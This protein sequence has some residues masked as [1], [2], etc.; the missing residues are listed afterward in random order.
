MSLQSSM[1]LRENPHS[2]PAFDVRH[3]HRCLA[4]LNE[5]RHDMVSQSENLMQ[6]QQ[7]SVQ[8]HEVLEH[9]LNRMNQ[10]MSQSALEQSTLMELQEL[11]GALV[12]QSQTAAA[13]SVPTKQL[14]MSA[15]LASASPHSAHNNTKLAIVSEPS[16]ASNL[17]PTQPPRPAFLGAAIAGPFDSKSS[18][19]HAKS[20]EAIPPS[21]AVLPQPSGLMAAAG[22]AAPSATALLKGNVEL[23]FTQGIITLGRVCD[24]SAYLATGHLH[25]ASP[26]GHLTESAPRCV[27]CAQATVHPP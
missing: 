4:V 25:C 13:G 26:T 12:I 14:G 1:L 24:P 10:R 7:K 6:C 20:S 19:D 16:P 2:A 5:M 23:P 8:L 22:S 9:T 27:S 21:S 18:I 17:A 3:T 11:H 15:S